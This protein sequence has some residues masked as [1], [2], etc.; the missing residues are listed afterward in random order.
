MSDA[1]K[2][3]VKE[4]FDAINKGEVAGLTKNLDPKLHKAVEAAFHAARSGFKD[5]KLHIDDMIPEGDK[6]VTRWTMQGAHKGE[7]TFGQ[8]GAVKPTN[9]SLSVSGITIH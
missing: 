2:A 8:M 3:V 7:A 1:N 5:M 4:A 9:K 6:V